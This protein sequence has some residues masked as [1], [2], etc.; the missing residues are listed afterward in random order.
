MRSIVDRVVDAGPSR[1]VAVVS[2]DVVEEGFLEN[3]CC[4]NDGTEAC[5]VG[6]NLCG[7]RWAYLLPCHVPPIRLLLCIDLGCRN[8]TGAGG[9]GQVADGSKRGA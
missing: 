5:R 1:A 9:I 2:S 6:E 4:Y 3:S 7:C 8:A